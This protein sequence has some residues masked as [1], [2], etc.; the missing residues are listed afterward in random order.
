MARYH[1]NPSTGEPGYCRAK[2]GNCPFL[3][4]GSVHFDTKEGARR[5]Y[6]EFEENGFQSLTAQLMV[7]QARV[8]R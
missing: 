7:N 8:Q 1:Y 3:A 5:G 4:Q 2:P 6:E